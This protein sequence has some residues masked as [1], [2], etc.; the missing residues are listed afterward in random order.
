[1][2]EWESGILLWS[3]YVFR[4]LTPSPPPHT[5]TEQ[6]GRSHNKYKYNFPQSL[7]FH[8]LSFLTERLNLKGR[9]TV[10]QKLENGKR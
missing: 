3:Q 10:L 6:Y 2:K 1:M 4:P 5:P 7:H 8:T 9:S